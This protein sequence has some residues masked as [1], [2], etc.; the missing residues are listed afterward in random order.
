MQ[1]CAAAN[2]PHNVFGVSWRARTH[3]LQ[4]QKSQMGPQEPWRQGHLCPQAECLAP[5]MPTSPGNR[6][7]RVAPTQWWGVEGRYVVEANGLES[8]EAA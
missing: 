7:P 5:P 3:E 1:G 6:P 2:R 8:E 4:G